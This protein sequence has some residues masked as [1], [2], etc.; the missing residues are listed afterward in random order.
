[1][2][3]KEKKGRKGGEK[4]HRAQ[5]DVFVNEILVLVF[6]GHSEVCSGFSKNPFLFNVMLNCEL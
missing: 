3:K 2:I 6:K 4:N 1:L 5:V